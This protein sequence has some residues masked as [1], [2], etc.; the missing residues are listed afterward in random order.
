MKP[1]KNASLIARLTDRVSA[2]YQKLLFKFSDVVKEIHK[3]VFSN[4]CVWVIVAMF[5]VSAYVCSSG[6]YYYTDDN[7]H[8]DKEDADKIE[9]IG[10]IKDDYGTQA[11]FI[12]D[13]GYEV[14]L[15]DNGLYRRIMITLALISGI[16]IISAGSIGVIK[17]LIFQTS[18]GQFMIVR[19]VAE[20]VAELIIILVMMK[21]GKSLGKRRYR[22]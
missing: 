14:I 22:V 3:L 5:V 7:K 19:Y 21:V 12:S 6:Q 11:W 17:S 4:K 18:V 10:H 20:L 16:M 13:R 1:Y 15:G 8:M 2:G 9:Y